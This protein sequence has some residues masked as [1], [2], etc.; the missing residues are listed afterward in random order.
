MNDRPPQNVT[1]HPAS[2]ITKHASR[3]KRRPGRPFKIKRD[4]S[5]KYESSSSQISSPTSTA[6]SIMATPPPRVLSKLESLP[7]EVIEKI[8]LYSLNPNLPR[9]SPYLAAAV[10]SDRIYGLLIALAFW[11]DS[12]ETD[13]Y[14]SEISRILSPMDYTVPLKRHERRVLQKAIFGCKWCTMARVR[15]QIPKMIILAIYR[16]WLGS[17]VDMQLEE[18]ANLQ[19]FLDREQD[20]QLS[21][22]NS[23]GTL[24]LHIIPMSCIVI[25]S[26]PLNFNHHYPAIDLIDFPEDQLRGSSTGFTVHDIAYLEMLRTA[27]YNWVYSGKK[28]WRYSQSE[29]HRQTMVNRTALHQGV[30]NAIR[31]QNLDA[32]FTLLRIDQFW[33]QFYPHTQRDHI[34]LIPRDHFIAVTKY[35]LDNLARSRKIF[36]ALFRASAESMPP[37]SP[38]ISQWIRDNNRQICMDNPTLKDWLQLDFLGFVSDFALLLPNHLEWMEHHVDATLFWF[39]QL[40]NKHLGETF[41]AEILP[42]ISPYKSYM[43]MTLFNTSG[44]WVNKP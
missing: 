34:Y 10:T 27:S 7:N 1:S 9:A 28:E 40:N 19:K 18:R 6:I 30:S 5:L 3:A 35:G 42:D 13:S 26:N 16:L 37:K 33:F 20:T 12:A 29:D 38:E 44:L 32:V 31:T 17:G 41:P 2:K 36:I 43:E 24:E 22:T 39:G 15:D 21:F 23:D 14:S 11:S 8:F 4:I 25:R